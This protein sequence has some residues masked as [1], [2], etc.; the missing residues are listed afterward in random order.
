MTVLLELKETNQSFKD[1]VIWW[2]EF[3]D[4][5]R[6]N[7]LKEEEHVEII[8][9]RIVKRL[10]KLPEDIAYAACNNPDKCGIS[11][12]ILPEFLNVTH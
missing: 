9:S 11:D 5:L 4:D 6:I 1:D 3:L 2:G 10:V 8:N 12:G 7:C